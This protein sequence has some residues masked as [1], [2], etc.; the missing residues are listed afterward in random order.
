LVIE[1]AEISKAI[2]GRVPVHLFW[3]REDDLKG[4]FYRAMALHN[5]RA[6]VD[7]KGSITGWRHRVVVRS[8]LTSTPMGANSVKNGIDP[9]S[10][11]G[12]SDTSYALGAF[13]VSL[14]TPQVPAIPVLWWRSSGHSHTA[15]VVETMIDELAVLGKR[16][17]V[18]FR[19][20][21]LANDPRAAAV[22]RL[23]ADKAGWK[24]PMAAGHG[25]GIAYHETF[26]TR[27]AMVAEVTVAADQLTVDRIVTVVDCGIAVNPD[28]I[29]N[30]IEGAV[31]FALSSVLRNRIT[32][33][34]GLI[35]QDSFEYYDPT[36]MREMPVV[37]VHIVPSDA[38]PSGISD[39]GVPPLAPAIGNAIFA[40]TGK[41]LRSLPLDLAMLGS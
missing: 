2:K 20:E 10:V 3:T 21:L 28:N 40:A 17:P 9:T 30:Q 38:P 14:H 12:L 13:T 1:L 6:G 8:I 34:D 19:A 27:V 39:P 31:G 32:L 5:V 37:E 26:G 41:R 35:G 25:R 24:S 11:E 36:R 18:A 29:S 4:G 33:K 23:A 16:D 22:L 15:H 7:D